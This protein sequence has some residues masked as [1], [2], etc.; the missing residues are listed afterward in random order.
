MKLISLNI[1]GGKLFEPLINFVDGCAHETNIFCFQEMHHVTAHGTVNKGTTSL[2]SEISGHLSGFRG[3][4]APTNKVESSEKERVETWNGLALFIRKPIKVISH[5]DV[6][7]HK[8][9]A[10]IEDP[11]H[12]SIPRNLQYVIFKNGGRKYLL[13]HFHGIWYPKTKVDTPERI[14][15][16][17]KIRNFLDSYRCRK[18]LCG[19][20]NLL[21]KTGSI[22]I[23][24]T[25]MRNMVTDF[26]IKTTRN[27][28]YTREEKHADYVLV[29]PDIKVKAFSVLDDV[30]SDHLPLFLEFE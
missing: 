7:I 25:G 17:K 6:V 29:T 26:K 9:A 5:G 30:V 18:I 23:L 19:D 20:F 27:I 21:P 16:S 28:H 24:E 14:E 12:K 3:I 11:E 22:E 1:W 13:C 10:T 4:F 15:Q 8:P 2:F